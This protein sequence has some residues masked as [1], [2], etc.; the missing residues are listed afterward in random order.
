M[1]ALDQPGPWTPPVGEPPLPLRKPHNGWPALVVAVAA[2][3]IG[4]CLGC[5]AG[6]ALVKPITDWAANPVVRV[7]LGWLHAD[8]TSDGVAGCLV[9]PWVGEVCA[10]VPLS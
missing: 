8:Y 3:L 9:L 2:I 1:R 5:A 6:A 10:K 7:D 4:T